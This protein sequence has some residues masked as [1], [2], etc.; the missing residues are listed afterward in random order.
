MVVFLICTVIFGLILIIM[1]ADG[2]SESGDYLDLPV[3]LRILIQIFRISLGDVQTNQYGKQ[4]WGDETNTDPEFLKAS[5]FAKTIIWIFW[6]FNLYFML[7]IM[8]NFLI[9]EV[10]QTYEKVKS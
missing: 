3:F 9:A 7:I 6:I 5:P 2:D 10:S 4:G 8:L 1:G